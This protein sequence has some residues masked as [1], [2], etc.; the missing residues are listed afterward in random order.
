MK[1]LR[2]SVILSVKMLASLSRW[3]K[4]LITSV[5]VI[6]LVLVIALYSF[7]STTEDIYF[8]QSETSFH[9]KKSSSHHCDVNPSLPAVYLFNIKTKLGVNYD[10]GHWFH[11]AE[12]LMVEHSLLRRKNGLIDVGNSGNET[13]I[14]Y[15]FDK[16][17]LSFLLVCILF[18]YTFVEGFS[19]NLNSITRFIMYLGTIK[20]K[21]SSSLSSSSL[22]MYF[23]EDPSLWK[24]N[25]QAGDRILVESSSLLKQKVLTVNSLVFCFIDCCSLLCAF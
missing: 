7:I 4:P 1:Q 9:D 24:K 17:E 11:M 13:L 3:K 19:S 12:N 22:N 6:I 23:L 8:D 21:I 2:N 15:N 10:A 5:T 20:E 25:I 16:S 18:R 14:L